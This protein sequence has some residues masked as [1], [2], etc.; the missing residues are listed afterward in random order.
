MLKEPL[1]VI[2]SSGSKFTLEHLITNKEKDY[3]ITDIKPFHFDPL[4]TNPVD[5][6]RKD[7]LEFFIKAIL[8][9]TSTKR[10]KKSQLKFYIKWLGYDDEHN[11]WEPY[12]NLRDMTV[13]HD[14]LRSHGMSNHI[15]PKFKDKQNNR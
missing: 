12:S 10:S 15:P 2:R 9:H 5:V 7:Y 8:K 1:R 14:Y 3:R 11:S 6:A 4:N 13:C